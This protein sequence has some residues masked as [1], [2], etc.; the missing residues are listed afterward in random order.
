MSSTSFVCGTGGWG[1]PLPGDPDSNLA[2]RAV[3]AFGGID[4]WISYPTVNPH[5]LAHTILYRGVSDNFDHAIRHTEFSGTFFHDRLDNENPI[6]Y[7]YWIQTV[8][9]NGTVGELVGPVSATARPS[10][11]QFLTQLT[12][13]IDAGVLAQSLQERIDKIEGLEEGL[14]QE[15]SHRANEHE[16]MTQ[17]FTS[18]QASVEETSSLLLE[19]VNVR[20]DA[21]STLAQA[22][23]TTQSTFGENI[24][25]TQVQMQTHV[26][27]INDEITSIGALYTAKVNVNGLIGGF[28]VYN[29]G[30][31]VEAGFDVD[32]FWV[33]RTNANKRKPFVIVGNETVIDEAVINR[34]TFSKLRDESG[35]LIVANG[36]I[37]AGYIT[38]ANAM[39]QSA[40]IANG[41]ITNAKILDGAITN[42]KIANAA[43][44]AAKITDAAI[45]SAKIGN[46][47][48]DRIH[49]KEGAVTIAFDMTFA[50]HSD[51]TPKDVWT[52]VRTVNINL[53]SAGKGFLTFQLSSGSSGSV[54]HATRLLLNGVLVHNQGY[55]INYAGVQIHEHFK[56]NVNFR[57]GANTFTIQKVQS[58][59]GYTGN[60]GIQMPTLT[61]SMVVWY[62]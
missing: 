14:R 18:L 52:T 50:G 59:N 46:A 61:A 57:A 43:I 19:E 20:S 12:G 9:V 27:H 21:F 39:I 35:N 34:L 58:R 51:I 49:L 24:A 45:T 17:A 54:G 33:G 62:R 11:E 31:E 8:S 3:P 16:S 4:I 26:D 1:G 44:N 38:I 13:K 6:E 5:A 37:Q 55:G 32:T 42:A 53:P 15:A 47:Q 36:K 28:G 2:L 40:H 60:V 23:T 30:K 41:A 48:I 25:Q 22:I 29:D 7:F 56:F 10:I